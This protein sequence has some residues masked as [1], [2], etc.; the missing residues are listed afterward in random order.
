MPTAAATCRN[1]LGANGRITPVATI[2]RARAA[3]TTPPNSDGVTG[4]FSQCER[5]I[6]LIAARTTAATTSITGVCAPPT[7]TTSN[8]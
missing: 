4:G 5:G 1:K 6:F 3:R 8:N 2:Y 7:T